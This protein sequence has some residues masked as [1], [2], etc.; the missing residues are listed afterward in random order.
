MRLVFHDMLSLLPQIES[1]DRQ[2]GPYRGGR[3]TLGEHSTQTEPAFEQADASFD[4]TAKPLQLSEPSTVLMFSL[5][6]TE[7]AN[8]R[9]ADST[10][11]H[12]HKLVH[13]VG[14]V[15]ATV[16]G[17]LLGNL[18]ENLLGLLHQKNQLGLVT[19]IAPM[20][21]VVDDCSG[22]VLDQFQV[23]P[24]LHRF[25]EL[26][27]YDGP[28]L[29]IDKRHDA[30]WDGTFPGKFILRFLNQL[31]GELDLFAKF[32]LELG[33]R[34]CRQLLESLTALKQR[35]GSQFGYFLEDL[36]ALGFA[37]FGFGLRTGSPTGQGFLGCPH[38]TVNLLPQRTRRTAK[39][40][41]RLVQNPDIGGIGDLVFQ[42]GRVDAN[43][44]RFDRSVLDQMTDQL[45][46]QIRDSLFTEPLVELDQR[47]S[48]G[49]RFHQRQMAEIAPRQSF[50]HLNLDFF[51]AQSPARLEIHH[52]KINPRRRT[53]SPHTLLEQVF[54][55]LE[56][57]VMAQKLV[58]F[59]ELFVQ[60]IQTR[61]DKAVAKTQLLGYRFAHDL[62]LY[63]IHTFS[64]KNLLT[65]SVRTN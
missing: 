39:R 34:R 28:G 58:H 3:R 22:A 24:Q 26:A 35:I 36:F 44:A 48:I 49:N 57:L 6:S 42:G 62:S 7:S 63:T 53:S 1:K 2:T 10:D 23:A 40:A 38:V 46:V 9:N 33:G 21:L 25:V 8:L 27:L 4:A 54:T 60:L 52:P 45:L 19:G 51:V 56:Q 5:R 32:L 30:F 12:P 55:H 29:G 37:L 18:L 16:G 17:Q 15:I 65:F 14:A 20:N 11:S 61:I 41:H 31:F 64:A 50:P 47:G 43:P 59:I 13:I